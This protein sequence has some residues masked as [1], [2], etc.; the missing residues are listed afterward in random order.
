MSSVGLAS[1]WAYY[2]LKVFWRDPAALFFTAIMPLLFLFIFVTIFGKEKV[3]PMGEQINYATYYV[4]AIVGLGVIMA[5]FQ[6]LAISLTTLREFGILKRVR[7]TPLQTWV[8]IA[9][10]IGQAVAV[11]LLLV[12]LVVVIG[13]VVYG[14][15]IPDQTMPAF[16]VSIVIGAASFCCLGVAITAAI[17]SE[18]AAPAIANAIVLP[19][20]FI[21]G[22]FFSVDEGPK[23]LSQLADVFPVVHFVDALKTSFNPHTVGSGFE[24]ANL[25]V[26][27][28]WGVGGLVIA[29]LTFR[30]TP[31]AR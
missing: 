26:L 2:N 5:T 7:G 28:G 29:M 23:W 18:N 24:W 3:G 13:N 17:P 19:L 11:A 15:E 25:A 21:S 1:K 4:P 6:N 8:F 10:R 9:G 12:V 16:I 31:R 14:V 30:W 20:L 27:G 22:V